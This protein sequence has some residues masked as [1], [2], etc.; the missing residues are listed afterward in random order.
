[1]MHHAN[2]CNKY[3]IQAL[4]KKKSVFFKGLILRKSVFFECYFLRKS[5]FCILK[6]KIYNKI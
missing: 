5:V 3:P 2:S 6:S 1:M 4:K